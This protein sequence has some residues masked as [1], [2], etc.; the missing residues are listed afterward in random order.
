MSLAR[1]S[2]RRQAPSPVRSRTVIVLGALF[3]VAFGA[4]YA[5]VAF[6]RS[7]SGRPA[8][9]PGAE[10]TRGSDTDLARAD[11]KPAHRIRVGGLWMDETDVPNAQFQKFVEATG[12]VTTAEK[13][14]D[15]AEIMKQVPPGTPPPSGD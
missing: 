15:A 14:P 2:K 5:V 11:E 8:G 4:T 6:T 7:S 10:S 12:Y 9:I 13:P 1:K 3:A